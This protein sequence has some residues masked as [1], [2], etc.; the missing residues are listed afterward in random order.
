MKSKILLTIVILFCIAF[1]SNAQINKGNILLGGSFNFGSTKNIQPY[2]NNDYKYKSIFANIQIGKVVKE[3]TIAGLIFSYS[4]SGQHPTNFPD[5]NFNKN[6]QYSAG[7]FYRRYKKLLNNFYFFGEVDGMY[8]YS[9]NSQGYLQ[10]GSDKVKVIS[11][12]G[13]VSFVPGISYGICKSL[14]VELSMPNIISLSYL[15]SKINYTTPPTVNVNTKG[16]NFSFNANLNSNFL[17]NF[18]IGFKFLL[19]K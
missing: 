16:N 10:D 1:T 12:G 9:Q 2:Y 18:G 8:I 4:Y 13:S 15:S 3:N 19:G 11:N 5:S 14:Q 17:S 7:V 6:N